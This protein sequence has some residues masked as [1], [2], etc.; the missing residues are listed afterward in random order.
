MKPTT[1]FLGH[2]AG[3][4]GSTGPTRQR[5]TEQGHGL[6]GEKLADGEVTGGSVTTDVFPN[7]IHIDQYPKLAQRLA[8]ASSTAAARGGAPA[9]SGHDKLGLA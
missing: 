4:R 7:S 6:T 9:V 8:G 3:T 1:S 2:T 5:H